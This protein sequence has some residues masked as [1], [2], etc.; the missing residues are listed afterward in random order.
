[1]IKFTLVVYLENQLLTNKM[2]EQFDRL[3][4]RAIKTSLVKFHRC[5]L[6]A[7]MQQKH[8]NDSTLGDF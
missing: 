4:N 2:I 1:M 5:Q 6:E 7:M 8:G 3:L